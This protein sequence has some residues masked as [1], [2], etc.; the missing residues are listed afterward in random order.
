MWHIHKIPPKQQKKVAF[1]ATVDYI[2]Q[3]QTP[4]Y[5][6]TEAARDE[7]ILQFIHQNSEIMHCLYS[8]DTR[9]RLANYAPY[10][11]RIDLGNPI[12]RRFLAEG[13]GHGGYILLSSASTVQDILIQLRK[14]LIVRSEAGKNLYF[15]FY[16]PRV[17]RS[18]LPLCSQDDVSKLMGK[19]IETLFCETHDA[20]H[21][22]HC[23][24]H[25]PRL[26][27]RISGIKRDYRLSH[28]TLIENAAYG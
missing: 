8:G 1:Q 9:I 11:F 13:W 4:C 15:R 20:K 24:A 23:H 27:R 17:L 16:D 18:Y 12:I 28:S 2:Q 25:T 10:L 26:L 22:F 14:T 3:T 7:S 6:V 19:Q 21:L 5:A